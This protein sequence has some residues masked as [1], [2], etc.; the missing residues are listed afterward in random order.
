MRLRCHTREGHG[1]EMGSGHSRRGRG[2]GRGGRGGGLSRQNSANRKHRVSCR[3]PR[4]MVHSDYDEVNFSPEG[5]QPELFE[6]V[7]S[8]SDHTHTASLLAICG[9]VLTCLRTAVP[10]SFVPLFC[11]CDCSGLGTDKKRFASCVI[12]FPLLNFVLFK[13]Y[14]SVCKVCM[15]FDAVINHRCTSITRGPESRRMVCPLESAKI[16]RADSCT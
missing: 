16:H 14:C 11:W 10:R 9:I 15:L 7:A 1:D 3:N 5:I 8:A 4:W 12:R 13:R 2:G 6:R